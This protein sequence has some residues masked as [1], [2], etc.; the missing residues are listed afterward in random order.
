MSENETEMPT[1]VLEGKT[2]HPRPYFWRNVGILFSGFAVVVLI[3]SMGMASYGLLSVMSCIAEKVTY[4]ADGFR[5]SQNTAVLAQKSVATVEQTLQQNTTLLQNQAQTIADLQKS[6]H[7]SKDDFL[8]EEAL[9]LVKLANNNIQ[10]ENN[11]PVAIKLL[12]S[13]DQDIAKLTDPKIY[14]VRKDFAAD[15]AAL[16]AAPEVDVTG[17]YVRL[18]ALNDQLD[19]LPVLNKFASMQ[20]QTPQEKNNDNASWWRRGLNTMSDVL[21]RIVIVR[22]NQPNI[23]PFIA[24]DQQVFLYQNLHA[25]LEKAQWGLLHHQPD[26]YRKSLQQTV[27]WIKQYVALDSIMTKQALT[28]LQQ[29]QAIDVHPALPS[30]NNSL[31]AIQSYVNTMGR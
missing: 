21:Q 20:V 26:I 30:V 7:S 12:Q 11:L 6:Q 28:E 17:V 2:K 27:N 23:P 4:L 3:V 10:F 15:L 8:A 19:K 25:Q 9:Y 1:P 5:E 22:K 14:A 31:Q 16:Q 24:P 18:S 13:A 29:L